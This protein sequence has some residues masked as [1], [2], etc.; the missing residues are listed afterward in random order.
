MTGRA[1]GHQAGELGDPRL[2]VV[3]DQQRVGAAT[4]ALVMVAEE[5][6]IAQPGKVPPVPA[7]ALV[8]APAFPGCV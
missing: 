4:P 2:A 3:N 8:G 1:E 7:R 5:N 6:L